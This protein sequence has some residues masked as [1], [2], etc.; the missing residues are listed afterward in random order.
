MTDPSGRDPWWYEDP[1]SETTVAPASGY[2]EFEARERRCHERDYLATI[3]GHDPGKCDANVLIEYPHESLDAI[4]TLPVVGEPADALNAALYCA[5]GDF[6]NAGIS[7]GA[8]IPVVGN[9]ITTGRYVGRGAV[10]Y[11]RHFDSS[12]FNQLMR[13]GARDAQAIRLIL[14]ALDSDTAIRAMT[15]RSGNQVLLLSGNRNEGLK[16]LIGRHVTG[17][18]LGAYTTFFSERIKVGDVVDIVAQTVQNGTS[19]L[20]HS[21]QNWVYTWKHPTWGDVKVIVDTAGEVIS[22]FPSK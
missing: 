16:H 2:A 22:A 6:I 8:I 12:A 14:D 10:T 18:Y 3:S 19:V 7:L 11:L 15:D 17:E 13:L 1:H 21:T 4:G 5:E 9:G 20:D